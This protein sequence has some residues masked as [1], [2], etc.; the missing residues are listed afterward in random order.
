MQVIIIHYGFIHRAFLLEQA[1][2]L[3]IN[4]RD[5]VPAMFLFQGKVEAEHIKSTK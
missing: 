2:N 5:R 1:V 3:Y 4:Q